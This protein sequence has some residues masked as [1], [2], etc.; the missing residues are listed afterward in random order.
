MPALI[1][2][3]LL[4]CAPK[5]PAGIEP[6]APS[7]ELPTPG[8]MPAYTPP[9]PA[10]HELESGASLWVITDDQL[11]LVSVRAVFDGGA[12]LDPDGKWG[13]ATLA[14]EMMDEAAGDL[15]SV[16]LSKA[17]RLLASDLSVI[18]GRDSIEINLDTHADRLGLALELAADVALRPVFLADDWSRVKEQHENF[19]AQRSEDAD[20]IASYLYSY[21]YYGA[22]HPL[23]RAVDGTPSSVAALTLDD[24]K[25]AWRETIQP[26][27]ATFVVVGDVTLDEAIALFD[28]NFSEWPEPVEVAEREE[29]ASWS[30][31]PGAGRT[32]LVDMPGATQTS[33]RLVGD[34]F[35]WDD[36]LAPAAQL[37]NVAVGGSFTSRLNK[38]LRTDLGYTY[39]AY[40]G[41]IGRRDT[42]VF[43]VSTSVRKDA[44]TDALLKILET[45]ENGKEGFSE[46][47]ATKARAQLVSNAVNEAETRSRQ[48]GGLA[49]RARIELD[50]AGAAAELNATQ[51]ATAAQLSEAALEYWDAEQ[52]MIL[53]VGDKEWLLSELEKAGHEV[54][55]ITEPE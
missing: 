20:D 25:M 12:R 49:W 2:L 21:A 39:G 34:G 18:G 27:R 9:A 30:E 36:P 11:P 31:R 14:A 7:F 32:L 10:V 22:D 44:T 3:T 40:S 51:E 6:V 42:T 5:S 23:G 4:S 52:M 37:A 41:Y 1:L 48:A 45:L 16:E 33:I 26:E 13:R 24:L 8:A 50:P 15:T 19:L 54:E 17:L 43:R 35:D 53:L 47:E 46:E 28:E 55:L 29:P 38:L